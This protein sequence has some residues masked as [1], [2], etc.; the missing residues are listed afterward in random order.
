MAQNQN[1]LGKYSVKAATWARTKRPTAAYVWKVRLENKC[2]AKSKI[3][4]VQRNSSKAAQSVSVW[5]WL[6]LL[7]RGL[8]NR[9][10][11]RQ[12]EREPSSSSAAVVGRQQDKGGRRVAR[13]AADGRNKSRSFIARRPKSPLLSKRNLSLR[14]C[15]K[16][17]AT[18]FCLCCG[19]RRFLKIIISTVATLFLFDLA[20]ESFENRHLLMWKHKFISLWMVNAFG[21]RPIVFFSLFS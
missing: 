18:H 9:K 15:R 10:T 20:R 7:L 12:S 21:A 3:Q 13:A 8:Q 1:P 16:C 6:L 11:N 2:G 17:C 5:P 4:Q 19:G 14:E